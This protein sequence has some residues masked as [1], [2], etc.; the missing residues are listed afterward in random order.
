MNKPII[1]FALSS[2][3]ELADEICDYMK[4]NRG[5]CKIN[6]FAD[7]EI[8]IEPEESVRG[9]HV[10]LI[11]STCNP[12]SNNV[13][14]LLIALDACR[15]A[16]AAEITCVIPYFGYARQDRKSRPRQPITARLIADLL[17]V[18][19]ADRVVTIDLHAPQIQGFFK[20]PN[21]DL[22]AVSLFGQY[23]RAKHID[24]EIVVVSPDHGGATR[25]RKLAE[26]MPGTTVAIIDKRRM[27]PNVAESINLIGDVENKTAVIIDDII[28]TGGSLLGSIKMLYEKGA[29]EVYCCCTHGVLSQNAIDNIRTSPLKEVVLTNT[30]ALPPEKKDPKIKQ[31]SIAYMLAKTIEAIQRETPVSDIYEMFND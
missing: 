26:C 8:L 1:V 13:M 4:I 18:S 22:S 3:I 31:L 30:I 12:V 29:K 19:G 24:G 5:K 27:K 7:G 14:E 10:F 6:H 16:S 2:S 15:R 11:Q 20:I 9:K 25:A 28:D 17:E 21:D 23:F